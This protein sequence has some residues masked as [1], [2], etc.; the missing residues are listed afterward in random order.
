MLLRG[1]PIHA[2]ENPKAT[3]ML[4]EGHRIKWIGRAEDAGTA[5]QIIELDGALVA[6][7]FVD[8]HVHATSTGL[9]LEGLDLG[10]ATSLADALDRIERYA[11]VRRGR[12]VL[13]TGWDETRWPEHRAPTRTELDRA[14]YGAVVYLSRTDVHSAV[15]SSAL[16]AAVPEA[17]KAD[18]FNDSG[19]VRGDAHH[20]LR[21]AAY[22]AVSAG[23]RLAAQR[24]TRAHAASLGIAALHELSGPDI[25]G[26]DDL[27]GL[28]DLA[29]R[30]SGPRVVGY[31]GKHLDVE[32]AREL[33]CLGA[34]G[35]LFVDGSI[36]SHTAA[37]CNPYA[38][39]A[40]VGLSYLDAEEIREHVI[41]CTL[42]GLQAGFHAIGDRAVRTVI[43]GF[44]AAAEELGLP[45]IAAARHRIEHV[46]MVD[47]V[48]AA[49]MARLGIIASVQPAFDAAWGGT[50][51]MYAERL[52]VERAATLNPFAML[53]AAGVELAFG[54]DAPVTPLD[55]WGA[56]RAAV[57]HRTPTHA[58]PL[59]VAF[60]AHTV[61]GWRSARDDTA[62]A[63]RVGAPATF[64][65]WHVESLQAQTAGE[66]PLL[67][68][69]APERDLP[70]C[71]RTVLDGETIY[72]FGQMPD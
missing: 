55:P 62:G 31:W 3:A 63:L 41:A 22:A 50:D 60:A 16:L 6:P 67:P 28:L 17:R 15:V 20:I 64:A 39:Q 26:A 45:R 44:T 12:M 42:Q 58:L 11:R 10:A 38:D 71:L 29:R 53:H 1:G 5:D 13:G 32:T 54:S 21:R 65:I 57:Y 72:T 34:A 35:D 8:A 4:V 56:V 7:A 27:A 47:G 49:E 46:E 30:E 70:T 14:S 40:E 25:S 69:V 19:H 24:A 52:G 43:A 61:A 37:L 2:A 68:D 51:G 18:G 66:R 59:D 36:G 33:G 48:L 23:D 9:A